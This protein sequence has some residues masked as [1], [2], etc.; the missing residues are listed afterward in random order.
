MRRRAGLDLDEFQAYWRDR[1]GP[2][3][4]G[5]ATDLD[6]LRYVQV[7][8]I[9][10]EDHSRL[11]GPRGQMEDPYDGVAEV[12][13]ESLTSLQNALASKPGQA[14]GVALL[15]DERTFIDLARSPIW[16]SYE[17]PPR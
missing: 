9:P 7:H 4:A 11:W 15:A 12:W 5:F 1:H 2:L 8:T 6:V 16:L 17:Y 13:W 10:N 14:A 3:M